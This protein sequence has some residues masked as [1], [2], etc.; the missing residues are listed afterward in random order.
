MLLQVLLRVIFDCDI[1]LRSC[2]LIGVRFSIA[3]FTQTF[4]WLRYLRKLFLNCDLWLQFLRKRFFDCD[5]WLQSLCNLANV[6]ACNFRLR[7]SREL[8][9][10]DAPCLDAVSSGLSFAFGRFCFGS[11]FRTMRGRTQLFRTLSL[12]EAVYAVSF[13][14]FTRFWAVCAVSFGLCCIFQTV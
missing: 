5:L 4:L 2:N 7:S 9:F 8:F 6:L 13:G 11:F 3:I 10:L 1:R 14:L 12:L